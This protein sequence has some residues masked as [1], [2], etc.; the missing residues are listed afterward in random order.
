MNESLYEYYQG[1]P[2]ATLLILSRKPQDYTPEAFDVILGILNQR[3]IGEGDLQQVDVHFQ[4]IEVK[5][6]R[7]EAKKVKISD[8]ISDFFRPK[9]GMTAE[10][11]L[12]VAVVLL[13]LSYLITLAND[14]RTLF[15]K[16]FFPLNIIDIIYIPITIVLLLTKRK[17]GWIFLYAYM[18]FSFL[19]NLDFI[20][21]WMFEWHFWSR[22]PVTG[23]LT[24]LFFQLLFVLFLWRDDIA[25]YCKV[26]PRAKRYTAAFAVILAV[27]CILVIPYL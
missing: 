19:E 27:L 14:W 20:Y 17:W 1:L 5:K 24:A 21:H 25:G 9:N 6:Q 8:F 3:Q 12:P 4:G 10:R 16:Y 7:V 15:S 22:V 2:T 18:L 23:T 11:W 13:G 26:T